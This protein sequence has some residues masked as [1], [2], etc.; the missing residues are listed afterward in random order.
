MK[1]YLNLTGD[2]HEITI[3]PNGKGKIKI[4]SIF[5]EEKWSGIYIS[6]YPLILTA[7]P[8]KNYVFKGWNGD[9]VSEENTIEVTLDKDTSIEG[10][11]EA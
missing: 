2:F 4:N 1:Q 9:V 6:D 10:I 7:F 3:V 11:F 5:I 8:S